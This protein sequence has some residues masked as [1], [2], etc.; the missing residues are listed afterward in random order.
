MNGNERVAWAMP[1]CLDDMIFELTQHR[2][3]LCSALI[4]SGSVSVCARLNQFRR[5]SRCVRQM[6]EQTRLC[7]SKV[8]AIL[9]FI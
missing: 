7:K 9:A 4:G 5:L 1:N 6:A 2:K 8:R 3:L